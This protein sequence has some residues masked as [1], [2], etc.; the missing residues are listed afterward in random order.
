MTTTTNGKITDEEARRLSGDGATTPPY[1]ATTPPYMELPGTS[2][3]TLSKGSYRRS[4]WGRLSTVAVVNDDGTPLTQETEIRLGRVITVLEQVV[5]ELREQ[6]HLMK[7]HS[8]TRRR[9]RASS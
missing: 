4:Q 1:M 7:N 8:P 2:E 6:T 3:G 9:T 5:A